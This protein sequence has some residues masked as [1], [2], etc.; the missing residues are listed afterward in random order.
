MTVADMSLLCTSASIPDSCRLQLERT[1]IK[2]RI[3]D[4][5]EDQS[6]PHVNARHVRTSYGRRRT[7]LRDVG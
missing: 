5:K 1:K 3:E 7:R 6:L 4:A 2:R